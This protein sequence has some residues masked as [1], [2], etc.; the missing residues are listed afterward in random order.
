MN[1]EYTRVEMLEWLRKHFK[2]SGY[3][4]TLYSKEFLPARVAFYCLKKDND[5]IKEEIIIEPTTYESLSVDDF[6]PKLYI[7]NIEMKDK[8]PV[9]I[10][11]ASPIRFYQHY[12][13]Y[14]K[15]FLA[16]PDYVKENN[17]FLEFKKY[18]EEKGI[19]LLRI[20]KEKI[21]EIAIPRS[22]FDNTCA[23]LD[24]ADGKRKKIEN[25]INEYIEN[26]LHYLVYYPQ[27]IYTRRAIAGREEDAK[28]I[29]SFCLIDKQ[30][31][32]KKILFKKE[33]NLNYS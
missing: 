21:E 11:G 28:G 1:K 26:N 33:L 5:K 22:L 6:F 20:S 31:D 25:I 18:C 16:Y 29:I 14:A 10:P 3:E 23:L 13:S 32:L 24:E 15:I 7:P 27:P 19:G 12:F 30:Q 4:V 17:K 8:P 9:R 2:N